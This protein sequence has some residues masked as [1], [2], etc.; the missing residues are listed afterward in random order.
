MKYRILG[1]LLLSTSILFGIAFNQ[2][3]QYEFSRSI[4]IRSRAEKVFPFI[5]NPEKMNGWNPWLKPDP[6]VKLT[7]SGPAEGVGAQSTWDGNS[8]VGAGIATVTQSDSLKKVQ[9]KLEN[10]RPFK[11]ESLVEFTLE[12]QNGNPAE[13]KVTWKISG[14]S[15]FLV[16]LI[17][18]LFFN[19]E[20]MMT[21]TFDKG[22]LELKR[23]TET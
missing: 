12:S 17:C 9:T 13:T 19:R 11:G 21:E 15:P 10:L 22:L 8:E 5:N 16:R 14:E 18:L 2:P 6:N 4:V 1:I 20:K 3:A 7:Y 23:I